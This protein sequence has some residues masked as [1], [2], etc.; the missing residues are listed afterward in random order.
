MNDKNEELSIPATCE[1]CD[2]KHII[3][4]KVKDKK[5]WDEGAMIQD[6]LHYLTVGER[7]LLIRQTCSDCFDKFFPN[8]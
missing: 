4:V 8:P 7:E 6:V 3:V 1:Y 5:A 2:S